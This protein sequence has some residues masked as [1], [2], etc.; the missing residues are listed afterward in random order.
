MFSLN[1]S[2]YEPIHPIQEPFIKSTK[3][4]IFDILNRSI[5]I[6]TIYE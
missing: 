1:D 3:K 5:K 6:E 4:T 2:I